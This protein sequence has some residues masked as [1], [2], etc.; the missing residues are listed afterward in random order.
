MRKS[1]HD[2]CW[3]TT[4]RSEVKDQP[5]AIHNPSL[6]VEP[7][8]P[9]EQLKAREMSQPPVW[10]MYGD[11][12]IPYP[13]SF[14]TSQWGLT[15]LTIS[16]M[17]RHAQID[18]HTCRSISSSSKRSC[19]CSAKTQLNIF[20]IP[21]LPPPLLQPGWTTGRGCFLWKV[22]NSPLQ[23]HL[24]PKESMDKQLSFSHGMAL[25]LNIRDSQK[26]ARIKWFILVFTSQVEG[27]HLFFWKGRS[28]ISLTVRVAG[29]IFNLS[30]S[31]SRSADQAS[32][33]KINNFPAS[34]LHV[35]RS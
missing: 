30:T 31:Y 1:S 27:A 25:K 22:L 28:R 11:I 21:P 16:R 15:C 20:N 19:R 9:Q 10:I 35:L 29:D 24:Q 2:F 6:Q 3:K 17:P 7:G 32:G 12:C 34:P 26:E 23:L 14:P 5:K 33:W 8:D 4:P 13:H 18:G